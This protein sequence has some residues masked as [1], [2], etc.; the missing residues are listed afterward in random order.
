[1]CTWCR[2]YA[3]PLGANFGLWALLEQALGVR[4]TDRVTDC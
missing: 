2:T 1:M 4:P 3:S